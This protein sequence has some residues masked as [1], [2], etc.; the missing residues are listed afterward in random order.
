MK[1]K[2][3][4]AD[5]DLDNR[6]IAKEILEA[7]DFEVVLAIDGEEALAMIKSE[8]PAVVVLDMSMPKLNG[9]EVAK[10][11]REDASLRDIPLIAFTAHA[12]VGDQLKATTAGCDDYIS[13]PCPPRDL[14][15]KVKS[16]VAKQ[17]N[18]LQEKTS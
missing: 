9:W 1:I 6:T 2:V 15:A 13:K 11:V 4:V 10:L 14:V 8:R 3:L 5:D 12:L 17:R 7:F 16:W 18:P